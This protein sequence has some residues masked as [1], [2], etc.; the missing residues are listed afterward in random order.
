MSE[1]KTLHDAMTATFKARM[2]EVVHVEAYPDLNAEVR[3]PALLFALTAMPPAPD[4]GTGKVSITGRFQALIL[5]DPCWPHAPLQAATLAG[6]MVATLRGQYWDLDF[7]EEPTDI[8]AQPDGS[9][10]ELAQFVTWLVEWSQV[11]DLGELEW[12]WPD[13]SGTSL[14]FGF[15]PDTGP[16]NEERYTAPE[17]LP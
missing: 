17:A 16:G 14:A 13:E 2:P 5:V 12:P 10:P 9:S 6:Q 4:R 3:L 1:L 11:F 15:Y 8:S 7:V